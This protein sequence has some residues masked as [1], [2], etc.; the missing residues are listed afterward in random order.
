MR[1]QRWIASVFFTL[2]LTPAPAQLRGAAGGSSAGTVHVHIVFDND[3]AAGANLYVRLMEGSSS[4]PVA[5]T[6]TNSNGQADFRA[7]RVGTYHVIV[8]GD[9]IQTTESPVFEVDDR[10]ATQSQY[11]A[12]RRIE[13]AD[14]KSTGSKSSMVSVGGL[15]I[16]PKAQKQLDKAN[17]AMA[18][19]DWKKALE[20]LNKAIAIDPHYAAAYNNL[21]VLYARMNDDSPRAGSA[22]EGRQPGRSLRRSLREPGQTLSATEEFPQSRTSA[23]E[24][25]ECGSQ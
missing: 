15:N 4:T 20:Q 7:V 6:Y 17:E 25:R 18:R 3:R 19:Q 5:N 12:V 9:G 10:K 22:G 11:I 1:Y 2:V 24:G 14:S 16:S 8:S 23:R 21:G 13:D